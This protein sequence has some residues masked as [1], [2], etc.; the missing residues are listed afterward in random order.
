M[1]LIEVAI[2]ITRYKPKAQCRE[3]QTS[4]NCV[5]TGTRHEKQI[6][7]TTSYSLK[8]SPKWGTWLCDLSPPQW[9]LTLGEWQYLLIL[10]KDIF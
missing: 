1:Q 10:P 8:D 5:P 2:R 6:N 9:T 4:G 3:N 7:K